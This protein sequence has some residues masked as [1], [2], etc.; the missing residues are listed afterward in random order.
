MTLETTAKDR[1][2][3][4]VWQE[5]ISEK[6]FYLKTVATIIPNATAASAVNAPIMTDAEY[7]GK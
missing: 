4:G 1:L 6:S 2:G 7:A 3:S 5:D